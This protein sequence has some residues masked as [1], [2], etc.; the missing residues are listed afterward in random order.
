MS[1]RYS[2][3][4]SKFLICVLNWQHYI[5]KTGIVELHISSFPFIKGALLANGQDDIYI[6]FEFHNQLTR[7]MGISSHIAMWQNCWLLVGPIN[8]NLYTGL[9]CAEFWIIPRNDNWIFQQS[10]THTKNNQIMKVASTLWLRRR[11]KP[12]PHPI[13]HGRFRLDVAFG[14][15]FIHQQRQRAEEY[16]CILWGILL[17]NC[18]YYSF[19]GWEYWL[20]D[21]TRGIIWLDEKLF[22]G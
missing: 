18:D 7:L 14:T 19:D 6:I 12:K 11:S 17:L 3:A 5:T 22:P 21:S 4:A 9:L 10:S 20:W 16:L 13:P 15:D 2:S 8:H 1:Y